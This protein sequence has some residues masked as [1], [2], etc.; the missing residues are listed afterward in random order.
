MPMFCVIAKSFYTNSEKWET[1][2]VNFKS[3]P[4]T[5]RVQESDSPWIVCYSQFLLIEGK[6]HL[7]EPGEFQETPLLGQTA[8][9]CRTTSSGSM[10]IRRGSLP[11]SSMRTSISEAA[12]VPICVKG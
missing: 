6:R 8:L 2:R 7:L 4:E 3:V 9:D 12:S 1:M 10:E 11:G 5:P